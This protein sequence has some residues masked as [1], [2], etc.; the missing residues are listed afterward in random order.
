MEIQNKWHSQFVVL[1]LYDKDDVLHP[2]D[3]GASLFEAAQMIS[4]MGLD[5]FLNNSQAFS[6]EV[7]LPKRL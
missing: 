3:S 5:S 6:T 4:K 2:V 1:D 7:P